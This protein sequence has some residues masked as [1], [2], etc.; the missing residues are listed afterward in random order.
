MPVFYQPVKAFGSS[1]YN[2]SSITNLDVSVGINKCLE[3]HSES[4]V[5]IDAIVTSPSHLTP[6]DPTGWTSFH[7][8]ARFLLIARYYGVMKEYLQAKDAFPNA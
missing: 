8:G 3:T 5:V 6:V 7:F 1:F 4:D 2:G